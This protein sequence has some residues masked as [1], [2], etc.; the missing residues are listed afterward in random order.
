MHNDE[1]TTASCQSAISC[2]ALVNSTA[3]LGGERGRRI[4]ERQS[5]YFLV[6]LPTA[7]W[8]RRDVLR[9]PLSPTTYWH[10]GKELVGHPGYISFAI[11]AFARAPTAFIHLKSHN[12]AFLAPS[13]KFQP[14]PAV[15]SSRNRYALERRKNRYFIEI[16]PNFSR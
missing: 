4:E 2:T 9:D 1:R 15:S 3:D 5:I 6:F 10:S 8:G 12:V 7:W 11:L 16:P 14:P 13:K